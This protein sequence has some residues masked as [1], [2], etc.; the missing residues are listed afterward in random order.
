[1]DV[2]QGRVSAVRR[3]HLTGTAG[4]SSLNLF[5]P[6][7]FARRARFE[8]AGESARLLNRCAESP[9]CDRSPRGC[10]SIGPGFGR[11]G[12]SAGHTLRAKDLQLVQRSPVSSTAPLRKRIRRWRPPEK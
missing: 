11:A 8:S 9:S 4:R 2:N 7:P 1:V 5:F 6:L 10:E 3:P 12:E